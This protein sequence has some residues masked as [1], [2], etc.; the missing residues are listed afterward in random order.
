MKEFAIYTAARLGIFVVVYAAIIGIYLAV[1][2]GDTIPLFWPFLLAVLISAVASAVLLR[3]Q[4]DAFALAVQRRAEKGAAR[5]A[6]V[7]AE[8][9]RRHAEA[10]RTQAEQ[11]RAADEDEHR[12]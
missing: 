12:G 8:E 3:K 6:A 4:R 11:Q 10:E 2:D 1:S 7:Q 9:D 5:R